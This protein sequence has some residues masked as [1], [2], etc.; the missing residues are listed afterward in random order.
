MDLLGE[1]REKAENAALTAH[2]YNP[3]NYEKKK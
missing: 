1:R 3:A 2:L